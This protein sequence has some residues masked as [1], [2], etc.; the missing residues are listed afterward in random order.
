MINHCL[1]RAVDV[2]QLLTKQIIEKIYILISKQARK[3]IYFVVM[4]CKR[5]LNYSHDV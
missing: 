3:V 1:L 2:P 5:A 4:S